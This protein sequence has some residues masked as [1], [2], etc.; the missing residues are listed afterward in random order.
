MPVNPP[1]GVAVLHFLVLGTLREVARR[2]PVFRIGIDVGVLMYRTE[3][4][5]LIRERL[6][7]RLLSTSF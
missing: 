3:M 6:V 4:A 7:N 1:A 2:V 5:G